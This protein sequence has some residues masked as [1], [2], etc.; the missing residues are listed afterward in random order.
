[1]TLTLG[2]APF[3][4]DP[5]EFNFERRGPSSVLYFEDCPREIRCE[6][7]GAI[8]ARSHRVKLLHESNRMPV[9]YFP[10]QDVR[11]ELLSPSATTTRCPF[12]GQA[13][14]LSLRAGDHPI[15]DLA[16]TYP[17]PIAGAPALAGYIAF[18]WHKIERWFE[19]DE[20][21]FVHARD[22]YHRI[23]I[24]PSSRPV[25]ISIGGEILAESPRPLFLF[26]T[27]LPTRYYFAADEVRYELFSPSTTASRCPY[28]GIA[29][30]FAVAAGGQAL[31]DLA[32]VYPDPLAEAARVA[33]RI[34][35]FNERVDIDV[36][37]E[38][39]PR[40]KKLR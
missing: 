26:E 7:A 6:V 38:I 39:Q 29:S 21:V 10:E 1:M 22:P 20:E 4:N 23:D 11:R 17:E 27:G 15:D 28:K 3:G 12:K 30:Y 2:K 16:W 13:R 31:D 34:S 36:D 9:Y 8:V 5:G 19:E 24:V 14:Y 32:W 33:G 40:P 37:G 18:T 35:F 25:K